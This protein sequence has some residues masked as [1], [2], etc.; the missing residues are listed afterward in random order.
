MMLVSWSAS[1]GS[2]NLASIA[3]C[4]PLNA[5]FMQFSTS[6]EP[7]GSWPPVDRANVS[8]SCAR[9]PNATREGYSASAKA[10]ALK[11]CGVAYT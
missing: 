11:P 10:T 2:W 6:A 5:P 4:V 3:S 1:A 8:P 9:Y 7:T